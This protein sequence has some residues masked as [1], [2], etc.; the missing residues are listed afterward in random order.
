MHECRRS[1]AASSA[2]QRALPS[3]RRRKDRAGD[4]RRSRL[5]TARLGPAQHVRHEVWC[6]RRALARSVAGRP[7]LFL[8]QLSGRGS[9][10]LVRP[11]LSF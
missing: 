9:V 11:M 3:R 4:C 10:R 8:Y 1:I 5:E 2:H 6:E 7:L